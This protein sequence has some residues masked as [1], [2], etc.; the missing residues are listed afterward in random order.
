MHRYHGNTEDGGHH[1]R[2]L[3]DFDHNVLKVK[4][5]H[6]GWAHIWQCNNHEPSGQSSH[7]YLESLYLLARC[8]SDGCFCLQLYCCYG[9]LSLWIISH[10]TLHIHSLKPCF[11]DCKVIKWAWNRA[12][13]FV[14]WCCRIEFPLQQQIG[15]IK[16]YANMMQ[17]WSWCALVI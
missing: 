9:A 13:I 10:H 14:Q 11:L 4:A 6:A 16:F 1:G 3:A 17:H 12:C 5:R 15:K 8:R 2:S 7:N